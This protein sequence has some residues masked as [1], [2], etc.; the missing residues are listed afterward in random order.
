MDGQV[1]GDYATVGVGVGV[2]LGSDREGAPCAGQRC[3]IDGCAL[4]SSC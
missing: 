4:A 2:S 1:S 3:A